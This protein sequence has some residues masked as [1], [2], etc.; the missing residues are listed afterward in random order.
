M[1]CLDAHAC[2]QTNQ[3]L[4]APPEARGS[5]APDLLLVQIGVQ[6]RVEMRPP[7]KQHRIA[8]QLEPGRELERWVVELLLQV[9]GRDVLS[10]LDFVLVDVKID[11]G[12]DE[13][14]VVDY[15]HE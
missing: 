11:V 2:L 6:A 13:Q 9:I 10:G 3:V 12:L 5:H 14:D 8:N 15:S 7:L 4:R 1:L